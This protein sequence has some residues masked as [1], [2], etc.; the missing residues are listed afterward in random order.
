MTFYFNGILLNVEKEP[1]EP[2]THWIE[3]ISYIFD[4]MNMNDQSHTISY[5]KQYSYIHVNK[6]FFD[7]VYPSNIEKEFNT[8]NV[9]RIDRTLMWN[10]YGDLI[11]ELFFEKCNI[12]IRSQED[13]Y[14]A[15]NN[16]KSCYDGN[17]FN[18]DV[19][20]MINN[21]QYGQLVSN[22]LII[23]DYSLNINASNSASTITRINNKEISNIRTKY[24]TIF[25]IYNLYDISNIKAFLSNIVNLL[26]D[27][28]T[29]YI[30]D[31]KPLND[32]QKSY[33][34]YVYD[35]FGKTYINNMQNM[36]LILNKI[37]LM[38]YDSNFTT[39]SFTS[40]SVFMKN[41]YIPSNIIFDRLNSYDAVVEDVLI[42][43]SGIQRG[44]IKVNENKYSI[45]VRL[46]KTYTEEDKKSKRLK[47]Y[48]Q[49][50]DKL[51][52]MFVDVKTI[53]IKKGLGDSEEF[54]YW[55]E[56]FKYIKK[57]ARKL[58]GKTIYIY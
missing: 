37:G 30:I 45:Y 4:N 23:S 14:I 25:I 11:K 18:E 33:F 21:M 40:S 5:L 50:F 47:E 35:V 15:S 32:D 38:N 53:G 44:E 28:G 13:L 57:M 2:L 20:S 48:R 24:D 42:L 1:T 39:K 9:I 10:Q 6:L 12:V 54:G 55:N 31:Y 46:N 8:K 43:R 19:L 3:R 17:I 41:S 16:N 34:T 36:N 26:T 29:L 49:V 52:D 51:T 27:D 58:P 7:T 22:L 56:L